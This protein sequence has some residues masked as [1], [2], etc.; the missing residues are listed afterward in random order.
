M[1]A[2]VKTVQGSAAF[3]MAC[4]E[5][6]RVFGELGAE[7]NVD[8][9]IIE[10]I[11]A[12][13]KLGAKKAKDFGLAR[14]SE[15]DAIKVVTAAKLHGG[16]QELIHCSRVRQLWLAL[17]GATKEAELI[18]KRGHDED[19]LDCL[20]PQGELDSLAA[21]F[22]IRHKITYPPEVAPADLVISKS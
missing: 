11:R 5:M 12:P 15:E 19:D 6:M 21:K 3:A 8:P 7:H 16:D 17:K 10:W 1:L 14:T 4:P 2:Q 13:Y 18:R 22:W 9:K 20:L